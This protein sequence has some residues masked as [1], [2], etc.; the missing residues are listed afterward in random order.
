MKAVL[1]IT[2]AAAIAF[3][4]IVQQSNKVNSPNVNGVNGDV[5]IIYGRSLTDEQVLAP[6]SSILAG[7][8]DLPSR[9]GRYVITFPPPNQ[10]VILRQNAASRVM[11]LYMAVSAGGFTLANAKGGLSVWTAEEWA[12]AKGDEIIKRS[13]K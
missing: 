1:L 12:E 8:G 10:C 9:S 7:V 2:I 11:A 4:Q 6:R 5:N 3:A 13:C